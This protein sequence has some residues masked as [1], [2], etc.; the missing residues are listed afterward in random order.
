M[1]LAITT[2][3]GLDQ[4]LGQGD[5]ISSLSLIFKHST[6]CALSS[7][8]KSRLEKQPNDRFRYYL[9][10]VIKHRDVS[11]A[12]AEISGVRHES[13]QAFL[14]RN[15][16]LIEVQSHMAINAASLASLADQ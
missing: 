2:P 11:N 7:M 1:W 14:Y 9:I 4:I 6:R 15:E 10:D 8:A 5:G 16:T 13:P 3:S 12:L